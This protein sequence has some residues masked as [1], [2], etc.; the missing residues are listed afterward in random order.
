MNIGIRLKKHGVDIL[1][2]LG[3]V[4]E[5]LQRPVRQRQPAHQPVPVRQRQQP[6]RVPVVA[7]LLVPV[8]Q[9]PGKKYE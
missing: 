8:R 7:R 2:I 1:G 6:V 4:L 3:F 5:R 9:Q